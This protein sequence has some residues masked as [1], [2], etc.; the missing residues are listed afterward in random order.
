MCKMSLYHQ[1]QAS[2]CIVSIWL[3]VNDCDG[4]GGQT[5]QCTPDTV[6]TGHYRVSNKMFMYS[7]IEP[8]KVEVHLSGSEPPQQMDVNIMSFFSPILSSH[9]DFLKSTRSQD[10]IRKKPA[11]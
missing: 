9:P 11:V 10:K 4:Y 8:C 7:Y 3:I 6:C 5:K 1:T 2:S